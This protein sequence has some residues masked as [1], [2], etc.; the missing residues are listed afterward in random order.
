MA[1]TRTRQIW[2]ARGALA[3]GIG[4]RS[5]H[6]IETLSFSLSTPRGYDLAVT[7]YS[8]LIAVLVSWFALYIVTRKDLGMV[9]LLVRG[10]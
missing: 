2:L 8:L 10:C 7:G 5:M 1:Y 9:R 6:F 3:M 4:I